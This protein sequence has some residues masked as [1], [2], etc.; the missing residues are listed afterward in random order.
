MKE[1][2]LKSFVMTILAAV[3]GAGLGVLG[4]IFV[5]AI[6]PP[7][8]HTTIL[9]QA[10]VVL[11]TEGMGTYNFFLSPIVSIIILAIT[12]I[13]AI[14]Y[15]FNFFKSLNPDFGLR[16]FRTHTI[17][18]IILILLALLCCSVAVYMVFTPVPMDFPG[19][20]T[21]SIL[22]VVI[23]GFSTGA[24][25]SLAGTTE[26]GS[27][28][29]SIIIPFF[30]GVVTF[31]V[32]SFLTYC[33]TYFCF[34]WIF[35]LVTEVWGGWGEANLHG[36]F[37]FLYTITASFA[38]AFA[39][40]GGFALVL[41]P[42]KIDVKSRLHFLII[43][44]ILIIG[45][46]IFLISFYGNAV[47]KYDFGKKTLAEACEVPEY[48]SDTL[49]VIVFGDTGGTFIEKWPLSVSA[50]SFIEAFEIDASIPSLKKIEEYVNSHPQQTLFTRSARDALWRGYERNWMVRK[51][52]AYHFI[53][54]KDYLITRMLFL[55]RLRKAPV[56]KETVSYADHFSDENKYSIGING[57][58]SLAQIYNHLG[59]FD[60]TKYWA[61]KSEK[62]E[63]IEIS[64]YPL[65]TDGIVSGKIMLNE[66]PFR[67]RVALFSTETDKVT[68]ISGIMNI[69]DAIET[70]NGIFSFENIGEGKYFL[71]V[72]IK[73]EVG[74]SG[75]EVRNNSGVISITSKTP[76]LDLG[77]ISIIIK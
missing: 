55:L 71:A 53:S 47:K 28:V 18:M 5:A 16:W 46:L 57:A 59:M 15:I 31:I 12:I 10:E 11:V 43:P 30:T 50:M 25:W 29:P 4:W 60:K 62:P 64:E 1:P 68:T 67:G 38:W 63:E 65:I 75:V 73:T 39:I 54:T 27:T 13:A 24:M 52:T 26:T 34:D 45:V 41:N 49:I 37:I 44:L 2:L 36:L 70:E 23:G 21:L 74:P 6:T 72:M 32:W 48:A 69:V 56:T 9:S 19:F 40:A 42:A 3:V 17:K 20:E 7:A 76:Q 8:V 33:A 35:K 14:I 61:L 22:A 51:A 77:D 66:K 58:R